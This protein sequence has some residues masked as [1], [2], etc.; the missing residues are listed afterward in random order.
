M[1]DKIFYGNV[2]GLLKSGKWTLSLGESAALIEITN[3]CKKRLDGFSMKT[4]D[5]PIQRAP[6]KRGPKPVGQSK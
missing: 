4:V 1:D 5:E 6:L 2:F 3:E